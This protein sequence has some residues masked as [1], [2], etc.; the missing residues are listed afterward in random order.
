VVNIC[1]VGL[2]AIGLPTAVVM[3]SRGH[4]VSGV[5]IEDSVVSGL[6]R[7]E[8]H[9]DEPGLSEL[10]R[11]VVTS[12]QFK[13]EAEPV[14]ADMYLICVPTFLTP[15]GRP[16][17]DSVKAAAGAV[18][19]VMPEGALVVLE[20]T[21]PPGTTAG[22]VK[23]VLEET[24]GLQ[25]GS[26]FSLAHCP[27]RVLPGNIMRE[28]VDND[29]IIGGVDATA[30]GKVAAIYATFVEGEL[31]RTDSASAEV[32]KL[33]ENIYRDVNIALANDLAVICEEIGVD[34]WE[35]I[36]LANL[37]P[38]V[39]IHQ[40]GPGV[41][42]YCVPLAAGFMLGDGDTN[43]PVIRSARKVND[44]QPARFVERVVEVI[45]RSGGTEIA[46]LGVSYKGGVGDPRY[47]PSTEIIQ[48][49]RDKGLNVRIHDPLVTRYGEPLLSLED[50]CRGA[51]LIAVL[52]D[53]PGFMQIDVQ[54]VAQLMRGTAVIDGR[55]VID[56]KVWESAGLT[57][58]RLGTP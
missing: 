1:V 44:S 2:G 13:A 25:A 10:L 38:R 28:I 42:G 48:R 21:V 27:E 26:G 45:A 53:H 39:N 19:R 57:V 55:N 20:S 22:L 17:L 8:T 4:Q 51:D 6:N 58:E 54:V 37:H 18:G 36:Q 29:R 30:T 46:V 41:G 3:A 50:A 43:A 9:F 16:I 24:S 34:V 31:V 33:A 49:L 32:V 11:E 5:D 47:S 15:E 35:A 14:A 52:V 40:P 12:G 23:D 7:G 56:V